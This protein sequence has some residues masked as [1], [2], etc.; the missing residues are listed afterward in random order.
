MAKD[1]FSDYS[2]TALSNSDV[3]GV[4]IGEGCDFGNMNNMGREIMSHIADHFASDTIASA[5]TCDLGS[6]AAVN[7]TISGTTTITG[8]GTVK[9][10]TSKTVTFSGALT[11]THNGTSLILPGAANITTVAGDTAEFTSL[12]SGNWKCRWFNRAASAPFGLLDEDDFASDSVVNAPSQ[13]ST[14]AYVG[15][16]TKGI[17][18]LTIAE[19]DILYGD[20]ANSVANLAKGTDGQFLSLTSGLPAWATLSVGIKAVTA[21][22]SSGTWNRATGATSALVIQTGGGGGGGGNNT[23]TDTGDGGGGGTT[24]TLVDVT[25]ISSST[26]TIGSGGSGNTGTGSGTTGGSTVWSDGTNTITAPGGTGGGSAGAAGSGGVP[27]TGTLNIPGG[28]GATH[29]SDGLHVGG[30]SFWGAGPAM[31]ISFSGAGNGVAATVFGSGGTGGTRGSSGDI[32]G[33]AGKA[34]VMLVIEF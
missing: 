16:A 6:K 23:G 12:G 29:S 18:G 34:G 27:T 32:N 7:L 21:F 22:T 4:A 26:I 15:A 11:L 28:D 31:Y 1:K 33:A 19:G 14:K 3:G 24:I 5:T 10:G 25:S 20:G 9:A 17:P 13:K 2:S 8:L 30:S